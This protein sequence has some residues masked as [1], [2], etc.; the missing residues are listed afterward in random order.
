MRGPTEIVENIV[1][2]GQLP[3][4]AE[5]YQLNTQLPVEQHVLQLEI[6]MHD[7]TTVE[8]D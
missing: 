2:L 1:L 6:A 7:V 8:V 5:V 3:A 4:E